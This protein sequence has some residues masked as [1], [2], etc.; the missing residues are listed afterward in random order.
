[1]KEYVEIYN[2]FGKDKPEEEQPLYHMNCAEVMLRAANDKYNF[3]LSEDSFRMLQGFGAGYYCEKTCGA[4]SG[5]LAAL[6]V[7]Y[8]EKRPSDQAEMTKVSKLL[9]KEFE[10]EFGSLNCDY[11]KEHHRDPETGCNPV[12]IRAGEVFNRV[13]EAIENEK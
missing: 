6:G 4:F 5:S 10:E 2:A 1:M 13:V 12:K 8:T 11:I 9:V 3:N 7:L